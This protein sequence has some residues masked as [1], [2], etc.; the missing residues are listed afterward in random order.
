VI[1]M[2]RGKEPAAVGVDARAAS[3]RDAELAA[4]PDDAAIVE[5]PMDA[6]V[7]HHDAGVRSI[8]THDAGATIG[9]HAGLITIQVLARPGDA[10]LFI[11]GGYSGPG[12]TNISR[13]Y[14]TRVTVECRAPHFKGKKQVVF[15]GSVTSVMCT[16]TRLPFC[17]DGLHNP[18]DDCEPAGPV[19]S[20]DGTSAP[21]PT[22]KPTP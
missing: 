9:R 1:V 10:N 15:D 19:T 13:P 6:A 21:G 7:P 3:P 2:T 16:A 11:D 5:L 22:T 17:V 14:G 12:G 18:I 4:V 8:A 20:P